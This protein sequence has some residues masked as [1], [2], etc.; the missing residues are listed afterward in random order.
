MAVLK[1][2]LNQPIKGIHSFKELPTLPGS[3]SNPGSGSFD[4]LESLDYGINA[5]QAINHL[6]NQVKVLEAALQRAREDSYKAGYDEARFIVERRFRED[7]SGLQNTYDAMVGSLKSKYDQSLESLSTPLAQFALQIAE[8]VLNKTLRDT[9]SQNE[10]LISQLQRFMKDAASQSRFIVK[11]NPRQLSW[12]TSE[13][14]TLKNRPLGSQLTFVPDE[15]LQPGECIVETDTAI[16][17]GLISD[18]LDH[19][20]QH[21]FD[22]DS[23]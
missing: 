16:I 1:V 17:Q 3:F 14:N 15:N 9:D 10:F 18:Y 7:I 4:D 8:K 22:G 13:K 12:I 6:R 5:R 21:L 23:R 20:S 2:P 11:V 19:I